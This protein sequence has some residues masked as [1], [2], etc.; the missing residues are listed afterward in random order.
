MKLFKKELTQSSARNGYCAS[1]HQLKWNMTLNMI[2]YKA[3]D[4]KA[5]KALG[6]IEQA[7]NFAKANWKILI[8]HFKSNK[9]GRNN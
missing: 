2:W 9:K 6:S 4:P 5:F 7:S 8:K 1:F 3:L